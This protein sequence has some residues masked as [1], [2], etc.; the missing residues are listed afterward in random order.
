MLICPCC[1]FKPEPRSTVVAAK[2]ELVELASRF[3]ARAPAAA[4]KI[5]FYRELKYVANER[6]YKQGWISHKFKEKFG[7]WPNG[8]HPLPPQPPSLTTLGWIRSRTIAWAKAQR[9]AP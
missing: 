8:L 2:G 6:G 3:A 4:E 5:V 7:H 1:G 9:R